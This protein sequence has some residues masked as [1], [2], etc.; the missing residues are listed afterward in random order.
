[1]RQPRTGWDGRWDVIPC[2]SLRERPGVTLSASGLAR[3]ISGRY[4]A[5]AN[6]PAS[7][8]PFADALARVEVLE[9]GGLF[10]GFPGFHHLY[11]RVCRTIT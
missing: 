5:S 8:A 4:T 11:V 7:D 2:A 9:V 6:L 3:F 1:M 10:G